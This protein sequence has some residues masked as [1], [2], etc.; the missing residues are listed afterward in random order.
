MAITKPEVVIEV[1]EQGA[2]QTAAEL[3]KVNRELDDIKRSADGAAASTRKLQSAQQ[4]QDR[5]AK[6]VVSTLGDLGERLDKDIE[7]RYGRIFKVTDRVNSVFGQFNTVVALG[8]LAVTGIAAAINHFTKDTEKAAKGSNIFAKSLK[9]IGDQ[10]RQAAADIDAVNMAAQGLANGRFDFTAAEQVTLQALARDEKARLKT[11]GDYNAQLLEIERNMRKGFGIAQGDLA[12]AQAKLD[13][14]LAALDTIREQRNAIKAA[15]AERGRVQAAAPRPTAAA[16]AGPG[17][18]GELPVL[19]G[20]LAEGREAEIDQALAELAFSFEDVGQVIGDQMVSAFDRA[21]QAAAGF[22]GLMAE[23]AEVTEQ[24]ST[25]GYD[26]SMSLAATAQGFG[27]T[28]L[29]AAIYGG[30]VK[31]AINQEAT[32][33][34][35]QASLGV[36]FATAQLG[37]AS[38]LNPAAVPGAQLAIAN[39]AAL[40]ALSA[41][42]AAATGGIGASGGGGGTSASQSFAPPTETDFGRDR[43]EQRETTVNVNLVAGGRP[44]RGQATTIA[45]GWDELQ[46]IAGRSLGGA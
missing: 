30:S 38:F 32:L 5:Q 9:A 18:P 10:A 42:F 1:G 34:F 25:S 13:A 29:M 39:Y 11:A 7:Q 23:G 36:L 15:A 4:A 45:V 31:D 3:E 27:Q 35:V 6:S 28:A 16:A 2:R 43:D 41:G 20:L 46:R 26:L 8:T 37:L 12:V 40:A 22:F 33:R 14:E 21:G 17:G 24:A 44:T 19:M